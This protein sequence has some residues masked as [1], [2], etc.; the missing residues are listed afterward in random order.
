MTPIQRAAEHLGGQAALAKLT[1]VTPQ[2]VNQ[3]C[4]G[5]RPVPPRHALVIERA[6]AGQVTARELRPDL[7]EVFGAATEQGGAA[8]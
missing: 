6:T 3:W 5:R 1:G 7:A 2:A 4:H 8:A